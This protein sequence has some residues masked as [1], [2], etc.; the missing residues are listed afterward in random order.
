MVTDQ[1]AVSFDFRHEGPTADVL[2]AG[3]AQFGLAGLTA[4]DYL[5][6]QLELEQRGRVLTR[7]I[8]TVTPF[9]AGRPRHHTRL[10]SA[11][12]S[13]LTALVGELVVPVQVAPQFTEGLLDWVEES[14]IDE[15]V[16]LSGVPLQH[17]PDE[18][19][20]F[21]VASEDYEAH[22]LTDA[23]VAPMGTGY[24]DGING[25][26]LERGI[27]TDLRVGVLV[28]PVHPQTPDVEAALRLLSA[29]ADIYDL[30]LEMDPLQAFAD[31]VANYYAGLHS[32]MTDVETGSDR[33]LPED[34][35]FM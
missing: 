6:E 27:E 22:R 15:I 31:D 32:R 5:H 30:D 13:P 12:E 23:D 35:M 18:H 7:G 9:D 21:Y 29:T 34:R 20:T 24:L 17:G 28:T 1:S 3:F 8:P 26:L 19:R 4:I 16:L 33:T 10:F 11:D 25:A 14:S 2:V